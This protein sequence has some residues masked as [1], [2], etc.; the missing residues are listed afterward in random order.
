MPSTSGER[1]LVALLAVARRLKARS[2][3]GGLDPASVFVLHQVQANAPLRV[4]ELARCVALDSSTVSRHVSH[5]EAGGYLTRVGDPADRRA[6]RV[7]LTGA[8][9]TLLDQ[10]M[11]ARAAML[12]RAVAD[13]SEAD[14]AALTRLMTRLADSIDHQAPQRETR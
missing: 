10:A 9:R 5:L 11:Q 6:T 3:A 2:A 7:Q 8:G 14:R 12:D 13:W 1:L 4:S